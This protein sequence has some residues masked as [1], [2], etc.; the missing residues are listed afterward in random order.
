MAN[1]NYVF[2]VR[3]SALFIWDNGLTS[4]WVASISLFA[5]LILASFI[6]FIKSSEKRANI[7]V[8]ERTKQLDIERA[9]SVQASKLAA[10]G[11]MSAGI[12][13]EIN[14]PLT[15]IQAHIGMLIGKLEAGPVPQDAILTSVIKIGNTSDRIG[16]IIKGL[17]SIARDGEGDPFEAV[18]VQKLADDVVS[19]SQNKMKNS[20]IKII[21]NLPIENIR[22]ECS[23]VQISQVLLNLV[24]NSHDAIIGLNPKWIIMEVKIIRDGSFLEFSITDCGTG[25]PKEYA[26]KLMQPFFTTKDVGKGTGLGLS[27]SRGIID[28]HNG[29]FYLDQNNA[30]TRFVFEIPIKN[31]RA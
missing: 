19:L 2:S 18:S 27:I 17:R 22:V 5:T 15:I 30:N 10:L 31:K 16:K 11:E 14:N 29:K 25:V 8:D 9:K 26:D 21:V 12:A 24:N 6:S 7:L 23:E 1:R 20:G 4:M 28:Q 13:H 3:P